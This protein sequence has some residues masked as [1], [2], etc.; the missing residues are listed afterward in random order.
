MAIDPEELKR[1]RAHRKLQ[2]EKQQ[3]SMKVKLIIAAVILVLCAVLIGVLASG[4]KDNSSAGAAPS[5]QTQPDQTVIHIAAAGDLNVTEKVTQ[6][7]GAEYDYTKTL[8]DAA[9]LLANADIT[10]LPVPVAATIRFLKLPLSSR[11]TRNLS[12]ICF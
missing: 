10:V 7:G 4:K 6:S 11:S 12:R 1:R 8:L 9:P 3:R 2:R 5:E